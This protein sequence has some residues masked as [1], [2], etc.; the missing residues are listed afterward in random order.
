MLSSWLVDRKTVVQL[1]RF[2]PKSGSW[3]PQMLSKCPR[4]AAASGLLEFRLLTSGSGIFPSSI[5]TVL[6]PEPGKVNFN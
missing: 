3:A 2:K 1:D 4:G 6:C 5:T